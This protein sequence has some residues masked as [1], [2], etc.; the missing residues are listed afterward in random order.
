MD[1]IKDLEPSASHSVVSHDITANQAVMCCCVA[2]ACVCV[3]VQSVFKADPVKQTDPGHRRI[4]EE[5]E[6]EERD[7]ERASGWE[8]RGWKDGDTGLDQQWDKARRRQETENGEN[9]DETE[10]EFLRPKQ[11]L[12]QRF[13]SALNLRH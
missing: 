6:E 10:T 1:L 9:E 8:K 5:E 4:E 2:W 11:S 12:V 3:S 7:W 13:I